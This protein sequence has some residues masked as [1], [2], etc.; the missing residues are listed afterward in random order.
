MMYVLVT[1]FIVTSAG[2][3]YHDRGRHAEDTQVFPIVARSRQ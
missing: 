1:F 2:L 3:G